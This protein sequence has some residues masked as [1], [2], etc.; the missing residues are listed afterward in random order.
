MNPGQIS[1]S[2]TI[3][4]TLSTFSDDE[5]AVF[6]SHVSTLKPEEFTGQYQRFA[7][8]QGE[9][10]L[11]AGLFSKLAAIPVLAAG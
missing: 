6:N 11:V 4:R 1:N 9:L 8:A 5:L 3:A 7:A 10:K 2:V